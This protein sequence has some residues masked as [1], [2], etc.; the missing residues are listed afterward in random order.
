MSR[1]NINETRYEPIV[2]L[3]SYYR[4][5]SHVFCI[6]NLLSGS[7]CKCNKTMRKKSTDRKREKRHLKDVGTSNVYQSNVRHENKNF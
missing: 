5:N 6:I 7:E 4:N 2:L 1:D 3:I